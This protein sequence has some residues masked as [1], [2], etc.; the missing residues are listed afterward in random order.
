M[1]DRL[2]KA[3]SFQQKEVRVNRKTNDFRAAPLI[4]GPI[5]I[6]GSVS[7]LRECL[8]AIIRIPS[9]SGVFVHLLS[10]IEHCGRDERYELEKE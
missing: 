3:S 9:N 8:P 2:E 7:D 4:N 6:Q 1:V 10:L 5:R